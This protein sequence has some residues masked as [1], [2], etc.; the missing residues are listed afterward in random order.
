MYAL[1]SDMGTRRFWKHFLVK[2][3]AAFG[4]LQAMYKA[5]VTW[6]GEMAWLHGDWVMALFVIVPLVAGVALSWPRPIAQTYDTPKTTIRI[7]N[8]D[9]LKEEDHLV[10]GMCDTFDTET[11]FNIIAPESLLGQLID[12]FY[13]NEVGD[14][15]AEL[16]KALHANVASGELPEGKKGKRATFDIGTVAPVKHNGRYLFFLA[17][18]TMDVHSNA[19]ATVD[20]VW[21]ALLA[22]WTAVSRDANEKSVSVPVIGG[23]KARIT[24]VLPAQ[25]AIRLTI[26]SFM[27]ASRQTPV[28]NELRIVVQPDA[29]DKLDRLEL[30]AFLSSLKGS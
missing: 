15:D 28:C 19:R 8:G 21:K 24:N 12:R 9:M 2:A 5:L 29:Y 25:D 30:Q 6:K 10:I 18:C 22:L 16:A 4:V 13:G 23:G 7:V 3:F 27:F 17:Y 11:R 14:L 26:L 20:G 1:V